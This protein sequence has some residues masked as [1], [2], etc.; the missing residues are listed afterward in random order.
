MSIS[1]RR[2]MGSAWQA[3]GGGTTP[4]D[5]SSYDWS[6]TNV[7]WAYSST[8]EFT[9]AW[10]SGVSIV[11]IQTGSGDFYT[12]L[13]NTVNAAPGRVVVRLGSGVYSL[14]KFRMIGASGN[15]TYS[16]GFWFPKLQ[17]FLGQGPDK[18]YIQ[19][20]ANATTVDTNGS[21]NRTADAHTY[22][23]QM[24]PA[25]FAP[26]QRGLCRFDGSAASPILLAGV[27]FRAADQLPLTAKYSD[28]GAL[29]GVYVPQPSPHQGVVLYS[30]LSAILSYV[31]FQA[32]GRAMSSAPPFEMSNL[33][34]QYGE[35]RI[36][37]CEFDGRRSPDLDPARPR[38]CGPLMGN[39]ED[40]HEMVDC[41]IHHSNISRYAVND[42]NR[43][44]QG[45]YIVTRCKAEQITNNQNRDPAINSGNSLGGYTNATPFGWESCNGTITVTDSTVVQDNSQSSGQVPCHFQLTSVGARNPQGGR[46]YLHGG[47]HGNNGFPGLDGYVTFRIATNTYWVSDGYN[48]TIFAYHK[49]GQRLL[50]YQYTG[51]WP[52]S[53]AT[54]QAAGVTPQTHYIVRAA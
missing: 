12:N 20:D 16:F 31:R 26:L 48:N 15:P 28:S 36:N 25:A 50:P 27:T 13:A 43:N 24:D 22:M 8:S 51:T 52:A 34:S 37:N 35:I 7:P 17:G 44:T 42:E 41:W 53:P 30:G 2:W 18:T 54:L 5:P 49:D 46:F 32:A 23:E 4:V 9:T 21:T 33:G 1:V 39:N 29:T 40:H 19:L 3:Y 38:R 14:N 45:V 47:Q 6:D 11:D 10:P